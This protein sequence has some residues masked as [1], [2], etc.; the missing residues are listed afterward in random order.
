MAKINPK[1]S[2]EEKLKIEI[3]SGLEINTQN[4]KL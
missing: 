1:L 3:I 4:C 2:R